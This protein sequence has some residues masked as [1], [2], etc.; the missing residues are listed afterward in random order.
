MRVSSFVISTNLNQSKPIATVV[1]ALTSIPPNLAIYSTQRASIVGMVRRILMILTHVKR[2]SHQQHVKQLHVLRQESHPTVESIVEALATQIVMQ[3]I[4]VCMLLVHLDRL[5]LYLV[6][7][8]LGA[9]VVTIKEKVLQVVLLV[10]IVLPVMDGVNVRTMLRVR[11]RIRN[12]VSDSAEKM[13]QQTQTF[14]QLVSQKEVPKTV[15]AQSGPISGT[16]AK[17]NAKIKVLTVQQQ[18]VQR[19]P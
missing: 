7:V 18:P 15:T 1:T 14:A 4:A 19:T 10:N 6:V 9:N 3:P 12:V 17:V 5:Q 8:S 16:A 11:I 2:R 13:Q